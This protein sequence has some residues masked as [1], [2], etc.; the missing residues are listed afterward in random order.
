[1]RAFSFVILVLSWAATAPA[2]NADRFPFQVVAGSGFV[3]GTGKIVIPPKYTQV[4]EFHEGVA[5]VMRNEKWGYV[6]SN[7][8]EVV[9]PIYRGA[10]DF[11][12]G[13]GLVM[14][15]AGHT[16]SVDHQW[17]AKVLD[18]IPLAPNDISSYVP[19]PFSEG[20]TEF[21]SGSDTLYIDRDC[22]R[23]IVQPGAG[24]P[25][26]DG[27]ASVRNGQKNGYIDHTGKMAIPMKFTFGCSFH[28][29]MAC[30]DIDGGG[31]GYIDRSGKFVIQPQFGGKSQDF[32]EG[33]AAVQIEKKMGYIDKNGKIVI[34]ATFDEAYDFS[35]GLAQVRNRT[36]KTAAHT[37]QD[38]TTGGDDIFFIDHSGK[39]AFAAH[40]EFAFADTFTHGLI[41]VVNHG[42]DTFVNRQ[43]ALVAPH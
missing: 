15:D 8:A 4:R 38:I 36:A 33:V 29:G 35:E 24:E 17:H 41:Y 9:A 22:N 16:A 40:F 42:T 1:M 11:S 37:Q 43:G 25:F 26:S 3:D 12:E 39:P 5:A 18:C 34:P 13:V 14:D 27:L 19:P 30:V 2:Q 28:E 32:S 7:G 23:V 20:L 31:R 21:Q 6:D 10:E